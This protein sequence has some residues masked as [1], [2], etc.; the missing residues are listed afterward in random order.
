M[1]SDQLPGLSE[2]NSHKR[3]EQQAEWWKENNKL[4]RL[5]HMTSS[6]KKETRSARPEPSAENDDSSHGE[7]KT[8]L[9]DTLRDRGDH[10]KW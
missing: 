5:L 3:A 1:D 7:F 8:S 10:Q 9:S 2:I 4:E 6:E